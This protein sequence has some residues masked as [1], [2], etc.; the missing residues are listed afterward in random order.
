MT[1]AIDWTT[2]LHEQLDFHYRLHLRPRLEGMTDEE[3][4]W[5]PVPGAW[6]IRP[7]AEATHQPRGRRR[8]PGAGLRLARTRR[9]R[10]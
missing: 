10:R 6:S 4:L 9:R 8:R 1:T 5:E 2:R 7:R 3:Y